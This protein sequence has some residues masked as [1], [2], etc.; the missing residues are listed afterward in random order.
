L[1]AVQRVESYCPKN[2]V[3]SRAVRVLAKAPHFA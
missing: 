1:R 2:Y 3:P